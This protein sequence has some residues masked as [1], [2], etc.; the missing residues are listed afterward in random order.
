L[1]SHSM[2]VQFNV[3][4]S[5]NKGLATTNGYRTTDARFKGPVYCIAL[6]AAFAVLTAAFSSFFFTCAARICISSSGARLRRFRVSVAGFKRCSPVI[7]SISSMAGRMPK[8]DYRKT[9]RIDVDV[10]LHSTDGLSAVA[11]RRHVD[12]IQ[13]MFPGLGITRPENVES[14]SPDRAGTPIVNLSIRVS[15]RERIETW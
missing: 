9:G 2:C 14:R 3:L 5:F 10:L 7:C 8:G 1:I 12:Q 6:P 4:Q 11:H 15:L 13:E